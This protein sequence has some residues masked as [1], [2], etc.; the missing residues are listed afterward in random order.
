MIIKGSNELRDLPKIILTELSD[1][2][3]KMVYVFGSYNSEY[4]ND[5]SDIDIAFY[6][7][8]TY[9]VYKIFLIAQKISASLKRE[10]DLVQMKLSTTVFQKQILETGELIYESDT[11]FRQQYELLVLKKYIRLNEE[12]KELIENYKVGL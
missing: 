11:G 3:L 7:E 5:E 8:N 2:N 12:R 4:F 10:V 9:D 1:L 6:S